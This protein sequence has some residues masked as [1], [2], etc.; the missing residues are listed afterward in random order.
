MAGSM[1]GS[2]VRGYRELG[3]SET[4]ALLFFAVLAMVL[5]I[6]VLSWPKLI[7]W[8]TAVLSALVS[9]SLVARAWRVRRGP[10]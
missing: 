5:A 10:R 1:V 8:P 4:G 3:P 6:S 7:A 2:A 9:L